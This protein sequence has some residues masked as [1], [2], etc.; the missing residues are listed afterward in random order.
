M[1]GIKDLFKTFKWYENLA[2]QMFGFDSPPYSQWRFIEYYFRVRFVVCRQCFV[3]TR[4]NS[5]YGT[6]ANIYLV[7]NSR[8]LLTIW[9]CEH[10]CQRVEFIS[11]H[12]ICLL[13]LAKLVLIL[14]SGKSFIIFVFIWI[15]LSDVVDCAAGI[16]LA[17][18]LRP[19]TVE[20]SCKIPVGLQS[21]ES[22]I[23][24]KVR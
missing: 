9:Y 4:Y 19:S 22:S 24:S 14:P 20:D 8:F 16:F 10:F 6:T 11:Q 23:K 12:N 1:G 17:V 7:E 5:R 21:D 18:I 15:F 13:Q 3:H 2:Y